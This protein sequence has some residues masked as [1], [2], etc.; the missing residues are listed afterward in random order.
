MAGEEIKLTPAERRMLR[1]TFQRHALPYLAAAGALAAW[2]LLAHPEPAAPEAGSLEPEAAS[3]APPL[4]EQPEFQAL[5]QEMER[6]LAQLADA[7][8]RDPQ[9]AGAAAR[10]LAALERRLEQAGRRVAELEEQLAA[11]RAAG[12]APAEAAGFQA[13]PLLDRVSQVELRQDRV[14]EARTALET[15]YARGQQ[16]LLRRFYQLEQRF[17]GFEQ[18]IAAV[19]PNAPGPAAPAR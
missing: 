14:D 1:R 17:D 10:Q 5:R 3:P 16:E 6:A 2:A 15:E 4:S 18:R 13:G 7:G 12:P 9:E 19:E 8:K 11:A